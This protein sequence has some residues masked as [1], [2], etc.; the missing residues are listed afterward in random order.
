MKERF[1]KMDNEFDFSTFFENF[2]TISDFSK[3]A[4]GAVLENL[5]AATT[6]PEDEKE[7]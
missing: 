3:V 4:L 5:A 6:E 1:N 7:N 2:E